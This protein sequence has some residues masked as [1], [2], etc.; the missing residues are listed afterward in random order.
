MKAYPSEQ[1]WGEKG[2]A[3]LVTKAQLMNCILNTKYQ[4]KRGNRKAQR[5][6][7]NPL[8]LSSASICLQPLEITVV[9][10]SFGHETGFVSDIGALP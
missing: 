8:F 3:K 10:C 9:L 2:L 6:H 4:V 7:V 5:F 1:Q